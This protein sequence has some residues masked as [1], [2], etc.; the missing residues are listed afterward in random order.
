MLSFFVRLLFIFQDP[1]GLLFDPVHSM[2]AVR[3]VIVIPQ[4]DAPATKNEYEPWKSTPT[5]VLDCNE[6]CV[7]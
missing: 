4:T 7:Y 5:E 2:P 6:Q 3:F 1:L